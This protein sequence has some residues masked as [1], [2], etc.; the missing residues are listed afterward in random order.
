MN[1]KIVDTGVIQTDYFLNGTA[2]KLYFRK[3]YTGI[4]IYGSSSSV[5]LTNHFEVVI[6]A[7]IEKKIIEPN[8]TSTGH[9]V[10]YRNSENEWDQISFEKTQGKISCKWIGETVSDED[11][12]ILIEKTTRLPKAKLP[13]RRDFGKRLVGWG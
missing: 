11:I 7:L 8:H 13:M 4:F 6:Y 2:Q 12:S 10:F 3:T 1:T 9:C 5:T